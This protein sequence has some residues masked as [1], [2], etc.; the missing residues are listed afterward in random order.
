M[1]DN[2]LDK[3]NNIDDCLIMHRAALSLPCE[4][5]RHTINK[6]TTIFNSLINTHHHLY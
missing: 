3:V 4:P 1:G 6:N 5:T 2:G